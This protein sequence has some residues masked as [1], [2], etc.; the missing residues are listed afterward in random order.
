MFIFLVHIPGGFLYSV[1]D[2]EYT[3]SMVSS[4]NIDSD[5]YYTWLADAT[6]RTTVSTD[7]TERA[8]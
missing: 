1:N 2:S 5:S 3:V 8:R 4:E 7:C 6:E